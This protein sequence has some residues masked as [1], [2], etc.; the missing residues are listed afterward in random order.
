MS[1]HIFLII[2][3]A[4]ALIAIIGGVWWWL[5]IRD[6]L[7]SDTDTVLI[8]FPNGSIYAEVAASVLKHSAGLSGRES[9][10][11]DHGMLFVFPKPQS[12]TF[13]MKGMRFPLDFI[14]IRNNVVVDISPHMQPPQ[15]TFDLSI[16]RPKELA[17]MA[18]EVNAGTV[19]RLGIKIGDPVE[20]IKNQ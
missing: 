3:F 10:G 20:I 4:C 5:L 11:I 19:K 12:L 1:S 17:N 7:F 18:L 2:G 14:W 8:R 6:T 13:W 15:N 9:L 16:V